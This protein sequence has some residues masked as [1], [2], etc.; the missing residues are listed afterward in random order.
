MPRLVVR[1]ALTSSIFLCIATIALLV[2]SLKTWDAIVW[3]RTEQN[4]CLIFSSGKMI[5]RAI[6]PPVTTD[7]SPLAWESGLRIGVTGQPGLFGCNSSTGQLQNG[8]PF[9]TMSLWFPLW[10]PSIL[11]IATWIYAAFAH[12]KK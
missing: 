12:P 9:K 5:Y 7:P 6:R 3:H 8:T 1:F 10:L 11:V 2:R 4:T